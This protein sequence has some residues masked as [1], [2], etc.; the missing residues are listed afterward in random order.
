MHILIFPSN[1]WARVCVVHSAFIWTYL[2]VHGFSLQLCPNCRLT[3]WLI[4]YILFIAVVTSI[5]SIW[6]FFQFNV[7]VVTWM[8]CCSSLVLW[9]PTLFLQT[10]CVLHWTVPVSEMSVVLWSISYSLIDEVLFHFLFCNSVTP[11]PATSK[12]RDND[13]SNIFAR[14]R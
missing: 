1:I 12:I 5:S 11:L 7:D 2:P 14:M 13:L 9:I 4:F 6:I 3:Q 8:D 10:C